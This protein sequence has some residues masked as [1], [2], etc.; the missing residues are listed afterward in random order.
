MLKSF[1]KATTILYEVDNLSEEM[2]EELVKLFQEAC[3]T[4]N[5]E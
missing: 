3:R 5:L 2:P 1:L 4:I